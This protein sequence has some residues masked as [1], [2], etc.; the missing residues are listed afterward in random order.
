[1]ERTCSNCIYWEKIANKATLGLCFYKLD[2]LNCPRTSNKDT[3]CIEWKTKPQPNI[4]PQPN[5]IEIIPGSLIWAIQQL[6]D[7]KCDD[8]AFK[9][10]PTQPLMRLVNKRKGLRLAGVADEFARFYYFPFD[11]WVIRKSST[12]SFGLDPL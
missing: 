6:M 4:I 9:E 8:V 11:G 10:N 12:K 1:M 7:G 3:V 2:F 5:K